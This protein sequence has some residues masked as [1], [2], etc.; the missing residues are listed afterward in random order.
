MAA[1][2]LKKEL[3][4]ETHY[5]NKVQMIPCERRGKGLAHH[6][7]KRYQ[8][9]ASRGWQPEGMGSRHHVVSMYNPETH[10][11]GKSSQLLKT[12]LAPSLASSSLDR[13]ET[14]EELMVLRTAMTMEMS[15]KSDVAAV[16]TI[17]W[18]TSASARKKTEH[19]IDDQ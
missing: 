13:A 11:A 7:D 12:M 6:F 18:T 2:Q 3:V 14:L 8:D 17:T 15:I 16:M 5:L 4:K 9:K 1:A 10:G 19:V